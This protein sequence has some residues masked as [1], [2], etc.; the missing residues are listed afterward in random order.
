MKGKRFK[1]PF[2]KGHLLPNALFFFAGLPKGSVVSIDVTKNCNLRCKHCYFFNSKHETELSPEGWSRRIDQLK[3]QYPFLYSVTWVGGEPLLRPR[4][5]EENMHKF[6]HNLVVTNGSIEF[7]MWEKMHFHVSID[8]DEA[9]HD[10]IRGQKGLYAKIRK[11]IDNAKGLEVSGAMV[12]TN[13]N[14]NSIGKVLEDFHGSNLA[15]F[16]FDFYT[17]SMGAYGKDSLCIDVYERDQIIDTIIGYKRG[18][19]SKLIFLPE[20]VFELMKSAN[21]NKVV[22]NCPLK[23]SAIALDTNGLKKPK[24]VMGADADCSKCGCIVPY[25]LFL[26]QDKKYIIKSVGHEIKKRLREAYV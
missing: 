6:I 7:P 15:G 21:M 14:K 26:R 1:T 5:I 4:I 13:T 2:L 12:I 11:N 25:Y 16:M 10:E 24:C 9:A 19:Y 22:K 18:K 8:G 23:R 3:K 20:E 17:P